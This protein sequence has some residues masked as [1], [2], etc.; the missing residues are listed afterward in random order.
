MN[1]LMHHASHLMSFDGL[2]HWCFLLALFGY[3]IS[4]AWVVV[5]VL[6]P[7]R[8]LANL[9]QHLSEGDFEA[10]AQ[11]IAGISEVERLRRHLHKMMGQIQAGQERELAYRN[12]LADS[13]EY[14]R[15]HIAREIHDETIQSLVLVA[16][17]IERATTAVETSKE[18]L[19]GHLKNARAQLLNSI[20][21]LRHL[22]G[23]LRPTVLDELGLVTAIETLCDSHHQ[24]EFEVVG[25][26]YE[27]NHA[28]EL[29]IFRTAQEAIRNAERHA[30]AEQINARLTYSETAV[31]LTIR[32]DGDGF[33][34]PHNV[35]E[36]ATRGHFGLLGIR[37]R[38]R[39][40][41]GQL[42]LT[43]AIH[44]GTEINVSFPLEK[45][46]IKT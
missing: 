11:P 22:I 16:H 46:L 17:H 28:Q 7:I 37:E 25:T 2:L 24:L 19:R 13:Q 35:Q 9:T 23:N 31:A 33:D 41:G 8:Q 36:F 27:I 18:D 3:F 10:F 32:D 40:L 20:E 5:R 21:Q 15:M 14:E 34:I 26:V 45:T 6:I 30:N 4:I 42:N 43:S 1:D 38:V 29:A 39:Y 12:N 44:Q